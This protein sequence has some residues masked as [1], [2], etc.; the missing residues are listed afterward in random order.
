M[1]AAE[2][3]LGLLQC[4]TGEQP[5]AAIVDFWD[6]L[7]DCL[8]D[9]EIDVDW[10]QQEM[11]LQSQV[12]S[13]PTALTGLTFGVANGYDAEPLHGDIIDLPELRELHFKF[14]W[15]RELTLR[16]PKLFNLIMEDCDLMGPVFL[17]ARLRHFQAGVF[18]CFLVAPWLPNDQFPGCDHPQYSVPVGGREQLMKALP[19][20]RK[21]QT[22][23]LGKNQAGLLQN[24]HKVSGR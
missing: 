19:L 11:L 22:L 15:G 10:K 8:T 2:R 1:H 23:E 4:K 12:L 18:W 17:Q 6:I 24:L 3:T 7:S 5:H 16:C 20:M 13:Q 9:L 21:L 14:Y